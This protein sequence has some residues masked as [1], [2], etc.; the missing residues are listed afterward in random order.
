MFSS[1]RWFDDG[2]AQGMQVG[3]KIGV[4]HLHHL[5][6][7]CAVYGRPERASSLS[8]LLERNNHLFP[9]FFDGEL[10]ACEEIARVLRESRHIEDPSFAVIRELHSWHIFA[11]LSEPLDYLW[12]SDAPLRRDTTLSR[13]IEGKVPRRHFC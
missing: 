6:I 9:V 3:V 10:E 12:Y 4:R 2:G 5:G 11:L 7:A 8:F 13:E 1:F